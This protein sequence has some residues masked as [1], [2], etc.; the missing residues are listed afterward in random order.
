MLMLIKL[1][2]IY[3]N[4]ELYF[5]LALYDCV[6]TYDRNVS[7]FFKKC[8]YVIIDRVAIACN[9]KYLQW[10]LKI[11]CKFNIPY[12]SFDYCYSNYQYFVH[13]S[14]KFDSYR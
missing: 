9:D 8:D 10:K 4:D 14:C 11:C 1:I 13:I 7:I 6:K 5:N 3:C 12:T 2:F